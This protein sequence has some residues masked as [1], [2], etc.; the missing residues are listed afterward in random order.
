MAPPRNSPF[1][2]DVPSDAESF[3]AGSSLRAT[4]GLPRSWLALATV[5]G[6]SA[7][8][9][10]VVLFGR[11]GG[12]SPQPG[13]A[14]ARVAN[15]LPLL[16]QPT[17]TTLPS[18][19]ALLPP[20][21]AGTPSPTSAGALQFGGGPVAPTVVALPTSA[22]PA[23]K[24][25]VSPNIPTVTPIDASPA[26][27]VRQFYGHLNNGDFQLAWDLLSPP[28]QAALDFETWV[29]GY[30]AT[31]SIHV[32][33][34]RVTAQNG[35]QATVE[36]SIAATDAAGTGVRT[37]AFAGTWEMIF[38][39]GRWMLDAPAMH[40]VSTATTTQS[41][42]TQATNNGLSAALARVQQ[43]GYT[44]RD[45]GT[46]APQFALQVLIG[47]ATGSADG[48]NRRAFFFFDD[49]YLGTD[50]TEPS[51]SVAIVWRNDTTIAL[52]YSLYR[53]VDPMCC[54]TGGSVTIRFQWSG[55]RLEAIDAIPLT[56]GTVSRR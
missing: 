49:Q 37:T 2:G 50:A 53:S 17:K 44:V 19:D 55:T 33:S 4:T 9:A 42:T 41:V 28:Y 3:D 35:P 10:I 23:S 34:T 54:P 5:I 45:V 36:V 26:E 11:T 13:P 48:Y 7:L 8:L 20:K 43:E 15:P 56:T 1:P 30:S 18:T 24:P 14:N 39:A 22:V 51:A 52:Q 29:K 16:A 21:P 6:L 27:S 12:Q 32:T 25:V 47:T 40:Q 46:Y 31:R 38:A